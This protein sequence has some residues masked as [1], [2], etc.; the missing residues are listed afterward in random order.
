MLTGKAFFSSIFEWLILFKM[1]IKMPSGNTLYL[2][3]SGLRGH[4]G[5]T[6]KA[7]VVHTEVTCSRDVLRD[8]LSM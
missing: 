6:K 7:C 1:N 8:I 3:W 2:R 5:V 4:V